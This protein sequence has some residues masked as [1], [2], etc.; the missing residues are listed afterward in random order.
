[1]SSEFVGCGQFKILLSLGRNEWL[2]PETTLENGFRGSLL[3]LETA[4]G[5]GSCLG[6]KGKMLSAS[7]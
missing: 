4:K 5:A 3:I 7:K 2:Y 1:M 6:K